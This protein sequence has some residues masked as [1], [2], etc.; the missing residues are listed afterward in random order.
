MSTSL[1][2]AHLNDVICIPFWMP[3][4]LWVERRLGL[5]RH[6]RPPEALEIAVLLIV[7]AAAFEVVIPSHPEWHIPTVGDPKDVLAYSVG[8]LVAAAVWHWWYRE[9]PVTPTEENGASSEG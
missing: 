5:R 3:I 9:S 8:S 7:I 2:R 4:M 6:D 1:L